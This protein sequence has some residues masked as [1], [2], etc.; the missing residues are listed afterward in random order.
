MAKSKSES[1]FAKKLD[2]ALARI[3]QIGGR[4]G[5]SPH[6]APLRQR[7]RFR[8]K[9][10]YGTTATVS[11]YARDLYEA[12]AQLYRNYPGAQILGLQLK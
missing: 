6:Q 2:R 4:V 5:L 9:T 3:G 7:F 11:Y 10:R 12:Q 8:I 1:E